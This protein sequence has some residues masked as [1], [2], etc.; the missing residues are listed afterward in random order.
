VDDYFKFTWVIEKCH[1]C[2]GIFYSLGFNFGINLH[3]FAVYAHISLITFGF[4]FQALIADWRVSSQVLGEKHEV[5]A[6]PS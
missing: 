1:I 3:Y 5:K 4:F 2:I 6:K